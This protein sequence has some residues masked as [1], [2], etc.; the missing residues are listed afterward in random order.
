MDA[1]YPMLLRILSW[2]TAVL[3]ITSLNACKKSKLVKIDPGFSKYIEAYTSGI[4][5]KKKAIRIQLTS[6]AEIAH[7]LNETIKEELFDFSPAVDGNAYWVDSRTIEFR[8]EKDLTPNE[9]YEVSFKLGKVRDVPSKF[10]TFTF[11][12]QVIKPSFALEESGLRA[13][14][15]SKDVMS[16]SGTILT[17]DVE[18]SKDV[19][20]I[21]TVRNAGSTPEIRWQHNNEN[22]THSF[23][24]DGIKRGSASHNLLL[25]WDGAAMKIDQ[26]DQKE[27]AIP[28]VGDFKVLAVRSMQEAEEYVLVQLSDPV[29]YNQDL[30]GL[31]VVSEQ[32]DIS[33]TI[34]GSEIKV[35]VANR[36]EGNY[37]VSINEGILN[38]WGNRLNKSFTANVFFENRLP[39]V[40]IHGRGTILT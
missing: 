15:N 3:L 11:N 35:Y 20:K 38:Q 9:L 34:N 12:V 13:A 27:I 7:S 30:K 4:I 19:E 16:Y 32:E 40:A 21:I 8:P 14:N 10:K 31:I 6:D 5:S 22:K 37:S 23:T 33:Y 26:K 39:S 28:A 36:L 24:I 1:R 29:A 2:L 25:E 17:A 18:E